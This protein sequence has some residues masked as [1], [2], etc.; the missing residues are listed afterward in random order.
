LKA[1]AELRVVVIDQLAQFTSVRA[2]EIIFEPL[3]LHLELSELLK[4]LS[5][6]GL[7]FLLFLAV[8]TSGEH[9]T[10]SLK[11]LPRRLVQLNRVDDVISGDLL[12]HLTTIDRL[13]GDF[14]LELWAVGAANA[15]R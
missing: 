3:Q 14:D 5:L 10:R 1:D 4:Q 7:V 11:E 8:L 2:A 9:L 15:N 12:V 13:L 6:I